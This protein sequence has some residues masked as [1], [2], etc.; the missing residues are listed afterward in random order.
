MAPPTTSSTPPGPT[1][2]NL[3]QSA[4]MASTTTTL[5]SSAIWWQQQG[6]QEGQQGWGV[7]A[8]G[9]GSQTAGA[10]FVCRHAWQPFVCTLLSLLACRPPHLAHEPADLLE[11][12]VDAGLVASLEQRGDGLKTEGARAGR[13]GWL[14]A[15]QGVVQS[16]QLRANTISS[17]QPPTNPAAPVSQVP[18]TWCQQ[19]PPAQGRCLTSVAMERLGSAISDSMSMLQLVT[20]MGCDMATWCGEA[21]AGSKCYTLQWPLHCSRAPSCSREARTLA[22]A[23]NLPSCHRPRPPC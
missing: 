2:G 14:A 18:A 10:G 21:R 20:A 9:L 23:S 15:R 22:A 16:N 4:L 17:Q 12:A 1:C 6:K 7:H 5:N 19:P 8:A 13:Q 11:Q 3:R